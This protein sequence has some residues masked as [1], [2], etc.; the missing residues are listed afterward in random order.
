MVA[1]SALW[2][3]IVLSALAVFVLSALAHT[4]LGYHW[5]DYRAV[6]NQGAALDALRALKLP[7]ASTRSLRPITSRRC[8]RPSTRPCMNADPS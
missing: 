5:N 6:P 4:V 1:I 8:A 2:L 3:P 7:R